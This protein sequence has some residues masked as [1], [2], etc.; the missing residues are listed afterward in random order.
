MSR[1]DEEFENVGLSSDKYELLRLPRVRQRVNHALLERAKRLESVSIYQGTINS[2]FGTITPNLG[3]LLGDLGSYDR[4]A[5]NVDLFFNAVPDVDPTALE[6]LHVGNGNVNELLA[7]I[8][9][10]VQ[11]SSVLGL[12]LI[13]YFPSVVLGDMNHF[14]FSEQKFDV[15]FFNW[16]LAYS[17]DPLSVV[18]QGISSLKAGG[19]IVIGWDV[20][21]ITYERGEGDS[22][23]IQLPHIENSCSIL[24]YFDQ[25]DIKYRVVFRREPYYP[26]DQ[27]GRQVVVILRIGNTHAESR[28][29][30]DVSE[31]KCLVRVRDQLSGH[32]DSSVRTRLESHIKSSRDQPQ[33]KL[34]YVLMRHH[35]TK[36]GS[37]VD[38]RITS[39]IAVAFP[40]V[41]G[42]NDTMFSKSIFSGI[43]N[44]EF[45]NAVTSL[46][47]RGLYVL[48]DK[49]PRKIINAL[50]STIN[51]PPSSTSRQEALESD[52]L[53]N[54][55]VRSLWLDVFFLRVA[56]SYFNSA[57]ILDFVYASRSSKFSNET[58]RSKSH[59]AQLWHYDKDRIKFLKIFIYLTDVGEENGPHEF[60]PGS[61]RNPPGID[62]RLTD[63]FVQSKYAGF[64]PVRVLGTAGTV[65]IE[66]T[67]GLHRG[68]PVLS[69]SRELLQLEYCN[70][71]FG[72]EHPKFELRDF[73][74]QFPNLVEKFPRLFY[75]FLP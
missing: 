57:P 41:I 18:K 35:Y 4:G 26:Y 63:E 64:E 74:L 9:H 54:A 24:R 27:F 68:T 72:E 52:L 69:N 43:D 58:L 61:H 11:P 55:L 31:S 29:R 66:D 32:P 70:S 6:V 39:S 17:R 56:E 50:R 75:R 36:Y 65:F 5:K 15:I 33:D 2:V 10:G 1:I 20:T 12:D 60:L 40:P 28:V 21:S 53:G 14:P 13:S 71:L 47:E 22:I 16:V 67:H 34:P 25:L 8:G 30:I 44:I 51:Y 7:S 49:V 45:E 19:Y 62:G 73:S 48:K 42:H 23:S 59:D 46:N 37:A 3:S 38:D